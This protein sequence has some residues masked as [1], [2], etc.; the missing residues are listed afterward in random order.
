MPWIALWNSSKKFPK[1]E[2]KKSR[3]GNGRYARVVAF[4]VDTSPERIQLETR[5]V[6]KVNVQRGKTKFY[7]LPR[8]SLV[9]SQENYEVLVPKPSSS[10]PIGRLFESVDVRA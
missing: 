2:P 7:G 1:A 9:K 8:I 5:A 6:E 10:A 3:Q 4:I